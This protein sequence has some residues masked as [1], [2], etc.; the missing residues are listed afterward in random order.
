MRRH[1]SGTIPGM[2]T[3]DL[4]LLK[5]PPAAPDLEAA[6]DGLIGRGV[7][8]PLPDEHDRAWYRNPHTG[9][10]FPLMLSFEA[11]AILASRLRQDR[12]DLTEESG[13]AEGDFDGAGDAGGP[14]LSAEDEADD[15][16]DTEEG[17]SDSPEPEAP[18][19]AMTLPTL[20]P[21]FVAREAIAVAAAIAG[22][23]HLRL[24]HPETGE[25]ETPGGS[26]DPAAPAGPSPEALFAGWDRARREFA[27]R[28]MDQGGKIEIPLGKGARITV[29]LTSWSP[30]KAE[31]WWRYGLARE[32]L[33]AA[34]K[35]EGIR[36]PFLQTAF[37]GGS[38]KTLCDWETWGR[39]A[40]PRTDL[41]LVRRR[42]LRKSFLKTK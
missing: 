3:F 18:V 16:D 26:G 41:V 20:C 13:A 15:E 19:V 42:R 38:V 1:H 30:A 36:V 31:S 9:V 8:E 24:A 35:D 6:V 12:A 34:L 22:D 23:A 33:A 28:I 11:A 25:A 7:I 39:A 5:D 10:S 17:E 32:E 4:Y 14:P 27:R 21:S 37:H 40:L 29:S 2:S